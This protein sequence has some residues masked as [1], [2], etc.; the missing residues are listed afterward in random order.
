MSTDPDLLALQVKIEHPDSLDPEE[1]EVLAL[2]LRGELLEHGVERVDPARAGEAPSGTRG[3]DALAVGGLI[4]TISKAADP[5]LN[6]VKA[7]QSWLSRNQARNIHIVLQGEP[8]GE[9]AELEATGLTAAEQRL[10]VDAF[11]KRM[12]SNG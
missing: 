3:I 6:L 10:L 7:L 1:L 9:R 2:Q 8:D 11:L 5:L 12:G 4:V